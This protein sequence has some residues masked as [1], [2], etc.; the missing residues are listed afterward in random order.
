VIGLAASVGRRHPARPNRQRQ[1]ERARVNG[2]PKAIPIAKRIDVKSLQSGNPKRPNRIRLR[3]IEPY[4]GI[5]AEPPNKAMPHLPRPA[6][7]LSP[8]ARVT[9]HHAARR[10]IGARR[11]ERSRLFQAAFFVESVGEKAA[12]PLF[13][14]GICRISQLF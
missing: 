8:R 3:H 9:A 10:A 5:Q 1:A 13:F 12:D 4:R 14:A 7:R 6:S 11:R 2:K